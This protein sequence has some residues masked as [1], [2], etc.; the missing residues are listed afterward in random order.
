[1]CAL[2]CAA[3]GVAQ[4]AVYSYVD[5]MSADVARGTAAGVITLPDQSTVKVTFAAQLPVGVPVATLYGAQVAAGQGTNYWNPID[6]YISPEVQNGPPGTDIIQ[7]SGG[8]SEVY[9]VTLSEPIE[10]P[11]LAIVDLGSAAQP[12]TYDFDSPFTIVSQGKGYFGGGPNALVQLPN[13]VLQGASGHGTIQFLGTFSTFS[14]T[15]PIPE[16]W[17]GFTFG[18]RTTLRMEPSPDGG[19]GGMDG[20]PDGG[21][22]DI[23]TDGGGQGGGSAGAGGGGAGGGEAGRG[24]QGGAAGAM[25]GMGG[26]RSGGAGGQ[27]GLAGRGG[28]GGKGQP[29]IAGVVGGFPGAAASGGAGGGAITGAAGTGGDAAGGGSGVPGKSGGGSGGCSCGVAGDGSS[30]AAAALLLLAVLGVGLSRARRMRA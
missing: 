19:V 11:I 10:D 5:W 27:A 23:G 7:L 1:V 9:T 2:A 30:D 18:I 16:T 26:G 17:H 29:A 25:G 6:P 24:G 22:G 15:V 12:I 20:G 21:G 8:K 3:S 4:A 13:N 28:A 14:W